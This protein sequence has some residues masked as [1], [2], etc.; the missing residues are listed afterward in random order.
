MNTGALGQSGGL[1]NFYSEQREKTH[2]IHANPSISQSA[3]HVVG[4]LFDVL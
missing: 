3:E 1:F 2:F 4:V